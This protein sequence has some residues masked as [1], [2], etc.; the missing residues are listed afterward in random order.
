MSYSIFSIFCWTNSFESFLNT[1]L[2]PAVNA[3]LPS[4]STFIFAT[5]DLEANN[6]C[7]SGIPIASSKDPPH[8]LII[9]TNFA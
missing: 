7:S 8:S 2:I 6:N 9:L 1:S 5:A 3:N 4:V